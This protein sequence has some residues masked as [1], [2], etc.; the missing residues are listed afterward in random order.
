ML[1]R[2]KNPNMGLYSPIGGKLDITT[3]ES[4]HDCALREIMEETELQLPNEDVTIIT[5]RKK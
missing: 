4:P 2:N 5:S 1:H 3:G